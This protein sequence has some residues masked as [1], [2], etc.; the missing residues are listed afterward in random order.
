MEEKLKVLIKIVDA[1][2]KQL[3]SSQQQIST[4]TKEYVK[5]AALIDKLGK[6]CLLYTSPSPRD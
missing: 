5:L 6:S 2:Q 1:Q 3:E 4:M